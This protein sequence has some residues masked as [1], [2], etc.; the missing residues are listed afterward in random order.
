MKNEIRESILVVLRS[1]VMELFSLTMDDIAPLGV[2][3]TLPTEKA[4]ADFV[5]T[6][7][8]VLA[9][10]VG[11][12]PA[13]IAEMLASAMAK[14][15]A[16]QQTSAGIAVTA[17]A[18]GFLNFLISD[19][20]LAHVVAEAIQA[21]QSYGSSERLARHVWEI[22][23]TSPNP[24][25]PMHIG[26]LRN[27][28]LS[29]ALIRL[30]EFAGA[31]IVAE[32]VDNNRGIAIARAMWG[33]LISKRRASAGTQSAAANA[34]AVNPPTLLSEWIAHPDQW[35]TPAEEQTKPDYFVGQCYLAGV[36]AAKK[37]S[38]SDAAIR[39]L[40]LKWEQDN[41]DV[42]ALWKLVVD[43]AHQGIETTLKRLGNRWDHVWHE[44][45]HYKMGKSIVEEGLAKGIFVR[46]DEGA[47]ITNLAEFNTP[48][49]VLLKSDGTALYITQDL[50]LTK[51][52]VEKHH[53]YRYL[54]VIGPEQSLAMKQM[55][56][57]AEQLGIGKRESFMHI[58]YGL[59]NMVDAQGNVRKMS[60]RGGETILADEL[61]DETKASLLAAGRDYT[62]DMAE[63]LA[64]S[65]VKY[66]LLRAARNSN[67]IFSTEKALS[68]EG[69][70]G[71]YV[72]YTYARMKSVIA[73]AAEAGVETGAITQPPAGAHFSTLERALAIEILHF[74]L[75]VEKALDEMS[76]HVLVEFITHISQRFN[77]LYAQE[78]FVTAE[79]VANT[80]KK[81][82]LTKALAG[83]SET[84]FGILGMKPLER[85]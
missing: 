84:I 22:D 63:S 70:S 2:D 81:V 5:S 64:V 1:A 32:A 14:R 80:T 65:A 29:M 39:D 75:L 46:G 25:K 51:L 57:V 68:M 10:K 40:A 31:E 73:K 34:S 13:A 50:A 20:M 9:K 83:I 36:D 35:L 56:L 42:W 54:W 77:A 24:N 69:D 16:N 76:P 17:V 52:K 43:Y 18:P 72:L 6:A 21:G 78:Q 59:V 85:V 27:N 53:A 71:V 28:V 3:I 26:H 12:S 62:P 41:A 61:L 67:I 58:T 74:P 44:H 37:D 47:I 60:S 23:H 55:F 7:A 33:F 19:D 79:D 66:S 11:K 49:T 15:F 30:F 45:E 4:K 82:F 38:A 8:F 48:D